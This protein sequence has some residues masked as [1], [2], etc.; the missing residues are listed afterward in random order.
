MMINTFA[1][2]E[3]LIIAVVLF[4]VPSRTNEN[5]IARHKD[6]LRIT[7]EE[8]DSSNNKDKNKTPIYFAPLNNYVGN[9]NTDVLKSE[10][11]K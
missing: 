5:S 8:I 2:F 7:S 3:F 4:I 9:I 6:G 1:F 10:S 11:G